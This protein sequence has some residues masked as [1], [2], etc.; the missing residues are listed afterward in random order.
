MLE[1]HHYQNAYAC[2][3]IAV[4]IDQFRGRGLTK[5]PHIIDVDQMVTTP[6]G[7]KH[8]VSRICFIWIGDL[9]YELIETIKDETGLYA[10]AQSN[11]GPLRFHHI[12]MRINDWDGFRARVDVQDMPLVMERDLGPDHLR[13]LYL[14]G[15]KAFGHYLE[16]TC[17]SDGMWEQLHG[18]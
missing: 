12:C 14:D 3:D 11:G 1:G 8:I 2:D 4:G 18:M 16:Y 13:F 17:M 15:R 5:E 6:A 7:P 9:Q 10:N